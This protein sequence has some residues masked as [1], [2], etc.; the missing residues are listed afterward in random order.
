MFNKSAIEHSVLCLEYYNNKSQ[1]TG[2]LV[3]KSSQVR[4]V[5]FDRALTFGSEHGGTLRG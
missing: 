2:T 4:Y 3:I 1:C 5:N